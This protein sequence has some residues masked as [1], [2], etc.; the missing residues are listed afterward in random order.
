MGIGRSIKDWL[1][2]VKII[3]HRGN[4]D[5]PEPSKE[6]QPDF[7]D[8]ALL[9]CD[10][11]EI[12]VWKIEGS[13]FLGHDSPDYKISKGFLDGKKLWCHAK[14]LE[15]LDF[16]LTNNF[17]CFWHQNDDQVLTSGGFIWTHS[18]SNDFTSKSIA[19]LIDGI[20]LPPLHCF[21]ICTDFP[22]KFLNVRD[23]HC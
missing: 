21:G 12:D 17:E 3:S 15:A 16:L 20:G 23:L 8:A 5:G 19:C 13:I 9:L 4:L 7:I 14:N 11:V 2:K 6:N 18:H 1:T 10:G 22:I